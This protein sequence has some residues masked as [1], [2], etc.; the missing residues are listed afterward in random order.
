M[1]K[2]IFLIV[3]WYGA[4][5]WYQEPMPFK[6]EALRFI[7][8]WYGVALISCGV[9]VIVAIVALI[10]IVVETKVWRKFNDWLEKPR[11]FKD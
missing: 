7:H 1:I 10:L 3:S 2:I 4:Y 8:I 5:Q 11:I 9:Q 6:E